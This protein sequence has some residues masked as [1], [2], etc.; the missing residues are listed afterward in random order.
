MFMYDPATFG[1][2]L[3][4]LQ[5]PPE[6]IRDVQTKLQQEGIAKAYYTQDLKSVRELK[7]SLPEN[8][9]NFVRAAAVDVGYI[10]RKC[11]MV[12]P[13]REACITH[14]HMVCYQGRNVDDAKGILKLEQLQYECKACSEKL[15]TVAEFRS[16]CNT[17]L[18]K[19]RI[20]KAL[21][22]S[23]ATFEKGAKES[24]NGTE[25]AATSGNTSNVDT[26]E[27]ETKRPKT[28]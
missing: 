20:K 16:H 28:E 1:T 6:A 3:T 27:P 5:I 23:T 14:Q 17:D 12:Y 10:C 4:M 24:Q 11:H 25:T 18:H 2:P 7:Q 21:A 26:N 19:Q 13:G 22:P 9:G 8:H 15:S